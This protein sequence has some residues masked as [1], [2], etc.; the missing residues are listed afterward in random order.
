MKHH[1]SSTTT[2]RNRKKAQAPAISIRYTRHIKKKSSE[3]HG[4][5]S[6]DKTNRELPLYYT[7]PIFKAKKH[8]PL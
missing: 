6:I 3:H 1:A 5:A 8:D 2:K 7:E 4:K